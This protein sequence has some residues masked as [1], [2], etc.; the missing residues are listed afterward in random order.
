MVTFSPTIS[1]TYS[2]HKDS[3]KNADDNKIVK[4]EQ[5]IQNNPQLQ[6]QILKLQETDAH[7]RA[8]EAAHK[9]AGGELAG[10][11]SYTFKTGPDGKK[12]AVAGEVPIAIEKGKTPQETISNM[13]KV[14]AAALAPSDPSAQDLKVAATAEAIA[15][16]ARMEEAKKG[17]LLNIKI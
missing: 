13:E 4:D 3:S 8:H 12:Y 11:A 9:A 16:Q 17:N 1:N 2:Y 10:G 5:D 14:K 6:E 7:V 15:N